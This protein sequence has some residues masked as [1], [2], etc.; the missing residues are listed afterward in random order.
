MALTR[1]KI[2][3]EDKWNIESIYK[4]NQEFDEYYNKLD[5][6]I[7][8]LSHK[9]TNFLDSKDNFT[10]FMLFDEKISILL[11]KLYVYDLKIGRAH[12]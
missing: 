9:L 3:K 11:E 7:D 8:E 4:D 10:D 1:D 6:M 12:V 5:T 2:K